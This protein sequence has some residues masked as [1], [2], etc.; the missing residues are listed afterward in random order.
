VEGGDAGNATVLWPTRTRPTTPGAGRPP[1][2]PPREEPGP[3]PTCGIPTPTTSSARLETSP[4]RPP[5][6][7]DDQ[8]NEVKLRDS[9]GRLRLPAYILI[10][11]VI[12]VAAILLVAA[13]L[14]LAPS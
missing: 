8:T 7:Q 14:L 4:T 1:S 11:L 6:G 12:A 13:G 5:N 2:P 10:A 9:S 3:C